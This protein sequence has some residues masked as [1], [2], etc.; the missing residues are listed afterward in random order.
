MRDGANLVE[1]APVGPDALL[2][3]LLAED[4]LA[5]MLVIMRQLLLRVGIVGRQSGGQL[6]LDLL[7]Q[8]VALGLAVRLGVERILQPVADLRL[9]LVVVRFVELRRG[10][11]PLRLAGLGH[12]LVDRG[13]NLLDLFVRKLDGREDHLFGLFLGARLDHHDA[14]FVADD[15]DVH[16]RRLRARR[17]WD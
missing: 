14:V 11:R 8:R 12:Q 2:R 3:H 13:D 9:Q 5:Q 7:D 16:R 10:K 4:P 1:G 15:H 6:I 17:R